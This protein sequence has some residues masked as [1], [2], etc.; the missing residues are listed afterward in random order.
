MR[1]SPCCVNLSALP[2]RFIRHWVSRPPS[3]RASGRSSATSVWKSQALLRARASAA[4]RAPSRP[5][6][7]P[8]SRAARAPCGRPR[9]SA[10]SS[11][12]LIRRSRCRPFTWTSLQ[13]LLQRLGQLAVQAVGHHLGE[14]EDRVQRRAQLVAHV[15]EEL[16]LGAAR[17][18][19]ARVQASSSA[20]ASRLMR[21]SRCELLAHV[22]HALR[23]RAELVAVGHGD[24]LVKSPAATCA[25]KAC[26]S[27]TGRMKDHEITKP[28][29]QASTHR[30]DGE[31]TPW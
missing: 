19:E 9:S 17:L 10:R 11:T 22:V 29:S 15:G 6:R 18:L 8:S 14:A 20:A 26:A 1:T 16:R 24:A 4:T 25:R 7:P 28:H 21:S 2:V 3:P 13:R 12:S 5:S 31:G 23:Q 27:R 30:G